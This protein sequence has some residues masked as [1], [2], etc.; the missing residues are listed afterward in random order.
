MVFNFVRSLSTIKRIVS[1]IFSEIWKSNEN[2]F[3]KYVNKSFFFSGDWKGISFLAWSCFTI[4]N[5]WIVNETLNICAIL[6]T[7]GFEEFFTKFKH[8]E[9][10]PEKTVS[11]KFNEKIFDNDLIWLA[12]GSQSLDA[13]NLDKSIFNPNDWITA[14]KI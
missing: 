12:I 1:H 9:I 14:C 11:W 3:E 13:S 10:I 5:D 2:F 8:F 4:S 6:N 7:K